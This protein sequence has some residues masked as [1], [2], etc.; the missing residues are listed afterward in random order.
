MLNFDDLRNKNLLKIFERYKPSKV[1]DIGANR[2]A[3]SLLALEKCAE[4][5]IALDLDNYSLDCLMEEIGKHN[6]KITIAKLN[7]MDYHEKPGYY[8]SYLPAHERLNSDFTICLAVVHHV[9]YFGNST[10]DEFAARLNRFAKNILI[11]EFVPYN[12][13]H[14]TGAAYKGKDRSWYTLENFIRA[15]KKYFPD[16]PEIFESTP[17]PRL[18]LKFNK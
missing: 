4:E 13:V 14:L 17:S 16:E 6:K 2:G 1:L 10:F 3:F 5:A 11:V 12:D 9:C 7:M 8:R 18:L 15:L